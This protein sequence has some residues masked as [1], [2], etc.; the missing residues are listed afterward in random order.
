MK[1]RLIV[2]LLVLAVC[3][4]AATA[5]TPLQFRWQKG[6]TLTYKVK[7]TTTVNEVISGKEQRFGS[8]LDLVKRYKVLDV[9]A[10]GIATLE[11]SLASM[12]NEQTRPN[13][14]VLLFDS[15]NPDK[16][17]PGLREQ[18]AKY[19]GTTLAVLRI[20][21]TGKVVEVR[22]GPADRYD[23]EPPFTLILPA[24][25]VAEKQMWTRSFDVVLNPPLGTGEKHQ[26]VQKSE[27]TKISADKATIALATSFKAM[28]ES[29]QERMPLL[30]KTNQGEAVFDVAA[31]RLL[32]VRLGVD[33][34][35]KDHQ[36]PGSSYHF[37][38]SSTEQ[39]VQ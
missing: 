2:V 6:L 19:V 24:T 25:G 35:L 13:G 23:A 36:G 16:S 18:L 27:C 17:T 14:E 30:Q 4:A 28:P 3:P 22:Q 5:Q 31:G 15:D 8:R 37:Q 11:Y 39:L 9:D 21:A 20:D 34:T 38:S 1:T 29:L 26:A 32:E 33:H 7:N 12:R 10:K